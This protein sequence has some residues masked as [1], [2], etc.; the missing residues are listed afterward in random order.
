VSYSPPPG[1]PWSS[2]QPAP[3]APVQYSPDGRWYW[4]GQQWVPAP[5]PAPSWSRPYS[6]ADSRATAAVAFV[7]IA[8]VAAG[9][10][11]LGETM[12]LVAAIAAPGSAVEVAGALVV[13][14]GEI[15]FVVG[16]VGG[17]VS[18]PMWMHRAF[19]NL[20]ALGAQGLRWS[21]AWAAGAWFIPIANLFVPYHVMKELWPGSDGEPLLV[22]RW[23]AAWIAAYALQV[24]SNQLARY[25][26]VGGDVTGILN[27]VVTVAAGVLLILVIRRITRYQ[28]ARYTE[29]Q[30]A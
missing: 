29:L 6:P 11:F 10:F 14:F 8:T 24:A 28:R 21:P 1:Q 25:T 4:D 17:A 7:A 19:R 12:D 13:L 5:S 26:R 30:G 9:V 18:V 22:R 16:L 3:S 20:P 27:D 15:V 23:W 2:P